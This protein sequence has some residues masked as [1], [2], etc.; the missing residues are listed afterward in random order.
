VVFPS[1]IGNLHCGSC[2][3]DAAHIREPSYPEGYRYCCESMG[4]PGTPCEQT[5][6]SATSTRRFRVIV[7]DWFRFLGRLDEPPILEGPHHSVLQ[8]FARFLRDERGLAEPTIKKQCDAAKEFLHSQD[9]AGQALFGVQLIE[10]FTFTSWGV[11]TRHS[12]L[13][14]GCGNAAAKK[15]PLGPGRLASDWMVRA[16]AGNLD[17]R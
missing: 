8:N 2:F 10:R 11:K 7:T 14:I 17:H 15:W 16:R 1:S 13:F 9:R 3:A 6:L 5:H 4:E 12:P